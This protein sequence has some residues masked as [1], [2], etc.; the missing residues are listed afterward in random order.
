MGSES[1]EQVKRSLERWRF[2]R[3][4]KMFRD[5]K[6][7]MRNDSNRFGDRAF[8]VSMRWFGHGQWR[9]SGHIGQ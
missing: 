6:D 2:S 4:R 3:E 9:D 8:T 1:K 5:Q 7:R